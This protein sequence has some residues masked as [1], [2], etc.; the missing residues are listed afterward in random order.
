MIDILRLGRNED[1]LPFIAILRCYRRSILNS[2]V[3]NSKKTG[4]RLAPKL[5][6]LSTTMLFLNALY[7]ILSY[8]A[9]WPKACF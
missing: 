9:N 7:V 3:L 6:L 5:Q 8:F 2:E 4:A 1:S